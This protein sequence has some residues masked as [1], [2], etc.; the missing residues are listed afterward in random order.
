[1][2]VTVFF[3]IILLAGGL[4]VPAWGEVLDINEDGLVGPEE[5]LEVVRLWREAAVPEGAG[6]SSWSLSGN[7]GTTPGTNFIGTTDN[8]RLELRVASQAALTLHPDGLS[9]RIVA[10]SPWNNS[11]DIAFGSVIAGGGSMALPNRIPQAFGVIGGGAGNVSSTFGTVSGG[12]NNMA[13]GFASVIGGGNANR[14]GGT[15]STIGGGVNN[16][17]GENGHATIAGGFANRV[18][19][20]YATVGGGEV[21]SATGAYSTV[22]GGA[23]NSAWAQDSTVGGGYFNQCVG[24]AATVSGGQGNSA[25]GQ[26]SAISGGVYNSAAGTYATVPGGYANSATGVASFAA[27]YQAEARHDASFVWSDNTGGHFTSTMPQQFLIRA[28]H[29]V[30]IGTNAPQTQFHVQDSISGGAGIGNHVAAIE[31]T[32]A[33]SSPDVLALKMNIE[34]PSTANNYITFMNNT[35][36]IG[37]IEGNGGGGIMLTTTSGDFAEFFPVAEGEEE[38]LL[39]G[40]I[41]GLWPQGVSRKTGGAAKVL[42]VSTDPI[43]LGKSPGGDSESS[44]YIPLA[45]LGQV[46]VAVVGE[47]QPGDCILASGNNDGFGVGRSSP[48]GALSE[49]ARVVGMA[50]EAHP[51][52]G[53]GTVSA[54]VGTAGDSGWRDLALAQE[55]RLADLEKEVRLLRR[56][57]ERITQNLEPQGSASLP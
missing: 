2:R 13:G 40:E 28:V 52:P 44:G 10:G 36:N 31:N 3:S 23:S 43:V 26:N 16:F 57:I 21:N 34:T 42:V 8:N 19:G 24:R 14:A 27:G 53:P 50:L 35:G 11:A 32:S 51:G 33:D 6:S 49:S 38:D 25:G 37:S 30:G 46:R 7:S 15:Y 17:I 54:L 41:V 12:S 22:A 4:A 18:A 56:E 55:G 1:M 5:I 9:P 48:Q 45:L 20:I 29:G 39:P 47:V